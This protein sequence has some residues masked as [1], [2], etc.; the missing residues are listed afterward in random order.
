MRERTPLHKTLINAAVIDGYLT[1]GAFKLIA[2]LYVLLQ[3][4]RE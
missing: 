4:E 3:H 2:F 1:T